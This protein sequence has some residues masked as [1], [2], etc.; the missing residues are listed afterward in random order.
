MKN[1]RLLI[2]ESAIAVITRY[3]Y[4]RSSMADIANEAGISRPAIYLHF[5]NKEQIVQAA[6]D[7]VA[8]QGLD[9]AENAMADC[10]GKNA[11]LKAFLGAYTLFYYRLIFAGPHAHELLMIEKQF[12][13][14][15]SRQYRL[16]V[17]GR[18]N[19]ILGLKD[20]DETGFI[21]A[22]ASEGIKIN[23]PDEKTLHSRISTLVDRFIADHS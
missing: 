18:I 7:L 17:V 4:R 1:K 11:R 2:L 13:E 22:G 10:S 19:A 14:E 20:R 3:G 8:Q 23:A 21:L 5:K 9:A 6:M 16:V 12:G 15:K